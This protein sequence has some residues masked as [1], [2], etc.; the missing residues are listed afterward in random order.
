[1]KIT[2]IDQTILSDILTSYL[3]DEAGDISITVNAQEE[4][5]ANITPKYSL[6]ANNN[7]NIINKL[8]LITNNISQSND[9]ITFSINSNTLI[10]DLFREIYETDHFP[11]IKKDLKTKH[12]ITKNIINN[13]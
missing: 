2:K 7:K 3:K 13:K 5:T 11:T 10:N 1:M 12:F 6:W 8:A 9:K 4:I